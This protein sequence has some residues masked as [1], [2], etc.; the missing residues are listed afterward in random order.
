MDSSIHEE[1]VAAKDSRID[2]QYYVMEEPVVI[3]SEDVKKA[4][5][6]V[7]AIEEVLDGLDENKIEKVRSKL[8]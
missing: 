7:L 8:G 1:I 6:F 3:S 2:A 4:R 5:A